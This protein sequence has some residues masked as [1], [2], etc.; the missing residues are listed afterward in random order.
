MNVSLNWLKTLVDIK[1]L[2]PEKMAEVLTVDGIP[3]D[4]IVYSGKGFKKIVTGKILE[5][6][7]HPDADH[8]LIC[9]LNAGQGKPIQIVTSADNV[10]PGQIVPVALSGA[11]LPAKH[12]AKA[13]GGL[14]FGDVK[15]KT[16]K[17][18]GVPSD[19]MMCSCG[20][21][22]LD[23]N[24]FPGV[25]RE[26][27]MILPP[28]T[29]VGVD[30]HE[31][32]N[33]DD[34]TYIMELTSN[35][36][37]CFSMFGMALETGAIFNRKVSLPE[38]TVR[39]EGDPVADKASVHIADEKY[40]RRFC[41]RLIENVKIQESPQWIQNRLRSNGIRPLNNIVDAANYV[42]LE[43]GQ[44]LHTYDYDK[45]GRHSLT[46]RF[47]KEGEK[48]VTLDE[49]ERD[50]STADLVIAD[51]DGKAVGIAGVMGGL[52]SEITDGT[53]NVLIESAV[54]DPASIRKTSRR[55]G[56][57][58]EASG[59]YERGINPSASVDAINRIC[60]IIEME[61]A[62]TV[63]RGMIDVYPHPARP[64][65]LKTTVSAIDQFIG[66]DIPK[67]TI[68]DILTRLHFTV[69]NNGDELTVTVPDFRSDLE[70]MPDLAEE[71]ARVYGYENI[72]DTTPRSDIV[73]GSFNGNQE[74]IMA[75]EDALAGDGLSQVINYSFMDKKDLPKLNFK[76]TDP[77]YEAIPIMNPISEEYPVMRTTLLP[78]LM[79]T[80]QY[81]L[82][83][84]NDEIS[85]FEEG[86]VYHPKELPLTELP[87]EEE[88]V[89]GLLMGSPAEE[90]YPNDA[91]PYDFFDIKGIMEDLMKHLGIYDYTIR[92]AG[93][94]V[95]HPG[96]SAEFVKDGKVLV[97]FGQLHPIVL[98]NFQLKKKVFGFVLSLDTVEPFI[99]KEVRYH[100][101][102]KFPASSRDLAILAPLSLTNEKIED[103]IRKAAGKHLEALRLFDMYRGSQVPEGFKSLAYTLSFRAPDRTLT[104]PEVDHWIKKIVD[105]L[106]SVNARLR[107]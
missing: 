41:C 78:G 70:G 54:F 106:E 45:V 65:V 31:V 29:P 55:L 102:P 17:L 36:G 49:K 52:N 15:I 38:I 47:A 16:G 62:G 101:I 8:L 61:N 13:P 33:Q 11:H 83:Q 63:D 14:K 86:H 12:D 9:Q 23:F 97:R 3:V 59:R 105:S 74:A 72:P 39:E 96:I 44:P 90:G 34:I 89:A 91:R 66:V 92:K 68:T 58:S 64:Q 10:K 94:P 20:E 46:C 26:G 25:S 56:L 87:E 18:R 7:K 73:K 19:G 75:V 107:D 37:D 80:L 76:E 103:V 22:G 60:Q 43:V 82:A 99:S 98:D 5:V 48:I 100:K 42:M 1:G 24:L 35:R 93:Y 51:G 28:D 77:V 88:M 40:C 21:L 85:I 30:F 6:K 57:R 50:L 4:Q 84:Q 67:E 71:V 69:K 27:I 81:N 104:D 53:K 2:D 95:F 32:L 79:H